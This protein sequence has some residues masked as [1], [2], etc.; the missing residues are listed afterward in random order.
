VNTE[1]VE[2][3]VLFIVSQLHSRYRFPTYS[4]VLYQ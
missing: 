1:P 3:K 4:P 2:W